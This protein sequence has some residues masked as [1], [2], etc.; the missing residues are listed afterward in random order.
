MND[1]VHQTLDVPHFVLS[2]PLQIATALFANASLQPHTLNLQFFL[3]LLSPFDFPIQFTVPVLLVLLDSPPG[4]LFPLPFDLPDC[5]HL[6]ALLAG[7]RL[8]LQC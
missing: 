4:L 3:R 7:L 1:L 5:A 8:C 6:Q 2:E